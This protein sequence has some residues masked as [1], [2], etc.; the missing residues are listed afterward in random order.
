MKWL[1]IQKQTQTQLKA[2]SIESDCE[3]TTC[4]VC[5]N[6]TICQKEGKGK[7]AYWICEACFYTY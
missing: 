1:E 7:D 2:G 3:Y 4:E 5:G 6:D